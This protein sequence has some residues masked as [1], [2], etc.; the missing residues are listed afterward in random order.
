[1]SQP[2]YTIELRPAVEQLVRKMTDRTLQRRLLAALTT[3]STNPR[4][5]GVDKLAGK[6]SA[7]Y[8][9]RVGDYRIVY[10]IEDAILLVVVVQ[11]ANRREIYHRL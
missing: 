7:L 9:I 3:L 2:V 10:T 1:M 8:R 4:P 5:P 11:I 6:K